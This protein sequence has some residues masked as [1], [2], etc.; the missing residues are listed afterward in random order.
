MFLHSEIWLRSKLLE[1]NKPREFNIFVTESK[2]VNEAAFAMIKSRMR[3]ISSSFLASVMRELERYI[4]RGPWITMDRDRREEFY[5]WNAANPQLSLSREQEAEGL[6]LLNSM[7]IKKGEIY[8]CFFARDSAYLESII[9]RDWSY[10]DYRDSDVEDFIPALEYLTSRGIKAIRMGAVVKRRMETKNPMIIDYATR[11][12][13][14]QGDIYLMKNCKFYLG[15]TSGIFILAAIFN[16]P[17]ALINITPMGLITRHAHDLFIPQKLWDNKAKR[18]LTFKE[19]I[20]TGK[21]RWC[22]SHQFKEA[23]ITL[24]RNTP[25]EI[26]ALAKEMNERIDGRWIE[27]DEDSMLQSKFKSLFRKD[28]IS[29]GARARIGSD[30]IRKNR[31]LLE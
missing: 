4:P 26:L 20:D 24:V 31:A 12:R 18:F 25:E 11:F 14:E 15:D 27:A 21:D 7:G 22:N 2:H 8:V 9:K 17:L 29:H 10:H 19:I 28:H 5:I 16:K 23:D 6:R 3:V 1:G 13:T 30:F